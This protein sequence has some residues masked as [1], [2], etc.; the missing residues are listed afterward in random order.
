VIINLVVNA[1]DAMPGGG[2]I[3]ISTSMDANSPARPVCITVKDSGTGMSDAVRRRAFEPF[4]TTKEVGKGTGLGLAVVYGIVTHADGDISIESVEGA[5][6]A[7]HIHL[8]ASRLPRE[9]LITPVAHPRLPGNESILVVEDEAAVR[10]FSV[11]VLQQ[12]GYR[13]SAVATGLEAL[14]F[15]EAG[16]A[17]DAIVT[18]VVMPQM[19]GPALIRTLA[20]G[21]RLYPVVFMSGYTSDGAALEDLLTER[22]C[23]LGKP[24]GPADLGAAVRRVL[25]PVDAR[26]G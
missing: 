11:N 7:V 20:E 15:L 2:G 24:F 9:R 23:F 17:V 21:G 18:D 1:R 6:T 19:G 8:P 26:Q 10:Q 13:V 25:D 5:G 12:L 3:R 4:F 22:S 14:R 16:V